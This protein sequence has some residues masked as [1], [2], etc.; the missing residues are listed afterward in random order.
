MTSSRLLEDEKMIIEWLDENEEKIE[1]SSWD[2]RKKMLS[3]LI[4]V[5]DKIKEG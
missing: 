4:S 2:Q 5:L 3:E 1:D